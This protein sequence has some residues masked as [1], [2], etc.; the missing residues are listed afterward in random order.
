M[1]TQRGWGRDAIVLGVGPGPTFPGFEGVFYTLYDNF[2]TPLAAGSVNATTAEPSGQARTVTDANSKLSIAGGVASFA[3][4]GVGAGNPGLW[5]PQMTRAAGLALLMDLVYVSGNVIVVGWDTDQVS[6][7]PFGFRV[8]VVDLTIHDNA[9]LISVGLVLSTGVPY[10]LAVVLRATG[11]LY[12]IKGGIFTKW[13]LAWIS[14]TST[15]NMYPSIAIGNATTAFTVDNLRIPVTLYVPSPLA[16]DTFTRANGALGS[17]ETAGPD[18]QNITALAW[19]FTTSIWTISTNKAIA[20]PVLGS[21]VIV[22]GAF[23]ADTNWGKGAGWAIA[24][25][26][27]NATTASSDLTA[28]VAPLT[29]NTFYQVVYT[30][31]A[32]SAG[33]VQAVVGGKAMPTHAANATYTEIALATT[34]AFKFTGAGFTGSLDNV[35]AKALTMA[36]CFASVQVSTADVIADV[37]VTIVGAS[38]GLPAGLV[39][40]LDSASSPA[41]FILCFLDGFLNCVLV[42]FVAGVATVK[43]TTAVTYSAGATLRVITD[44]TACRVFYNN[45]AVGTVQ[46]M[47]ANTNKNHGLFSPTASNSL[48]NFTIWPR[49]TGNEYGTLDLY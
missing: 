12:F 49:G 36:E 30:V 7:A 19:A 32:F 42:E 2:N 3:T 29:A 11:C 46:T 15:A 28:S 37:A 10:N 1:P 35:S 8:N 24:S 16:Y 21:D 23:A 18:S 26:T 45:A 31:S 44:G 9:T 20:T 40:N 6:T 25:G 41:N 34:T 39:L 27:A 5:Y 33:T 14:A 17:T 48:D 13:T 22:N 38:S 4:G 47:T 43:Q